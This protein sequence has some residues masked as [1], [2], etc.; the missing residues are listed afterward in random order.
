MA[1]LSVKDGEGRPLEV[2]AANEGFKQMTTK[3]LLRLL[4]AMKPD[5][6]KGQ[7]PTLED[8][9]VKYLVEHFIPS[10]SAEEIAAALAQRKTNGLQH[11][12]AECS[13]LAKGDNMDLMAECFD[14]GNVLD[15]E[16]D[17][18]SAKN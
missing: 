16:K 8:D 9:I 3:Y 12:V 15:V 5:F 10:A 18:T 7:R 6:E 17:V 4:D 2:I 1:L 11:D 13:V 14:E